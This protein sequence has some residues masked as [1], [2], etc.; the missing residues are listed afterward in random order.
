MADDFV[1]VFQDK[2]GNQGSD[3][4]ILVKHLYQINYNIWESIIRDSMV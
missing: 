4:S 2:A 3:E 1:T